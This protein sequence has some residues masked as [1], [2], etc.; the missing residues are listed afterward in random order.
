MTGTPLDLTPF[1]PLLSALGLLYWLL[2]IALI[3]FALWYPNRWLFK[4]PLAAL[5]LMVFAYPVVR[6]AQ[7]QQVQ[8][9]ESKA[10]LDAAMALFAERCKTAGE[11]ITRTVENV[12]G[13]VWMKWR[14]KITGVGTFADQFKLSDPYGQDCGAEDCI[15]NLLRV[16]DGAVHHSES[17]RRHGTGYRSVETVDPRT[18]EPYRY[19][20]VVGVTHRRTPEQ[21]EQYKRNTGTDPGLEVFGVVLKREPISDFK[22][23][24]GITWEDIS[25]REDRE[26]WIAGGAL[27]V[28]DLKT[29]EVIAKRVGYMIDT[30]QGSTAGFRSPWGWA[31]SYAPRCPNVD[32]RLKDFVVNVLQ[33]TKQGE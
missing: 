9:N 8:S 10:R 20:A 2:A 13:V 27:S 14:E 7:L 11:K 23:R 25:T 19:S 26:H 3:A 30:G 21:L 5:V 33:P 15:T 17:A 28:I 29:N 16:T 12:D 22:S 32:V 1:G 4:L 6:H 18:N 24:Y 31:R